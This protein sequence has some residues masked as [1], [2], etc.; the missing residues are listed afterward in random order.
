MSFEEFQNQARLYVIGALDLEELE[1]L[2]T[3]RKKSGE[4]ADDFITRC[5]ALHEAFAPKCEISPP[6]L[7][8]EHCVPCFFPSFNFMRVTTDR[9][10]RSDND[11]ILFFGQ[12]L[13]PDSIFHIREEL[14]SQMNDAMKW[15]NHLIQAVSELDREIS[16]KAVQKR[17]SSDAIFSSGV[18]NLLNLRPSQPARQKWVSPLM[19]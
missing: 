7:E 6:W 15:R 16:R 17:T 4:K 12:R 8:K 3:E 9:Y 11:Q 5:Y 1:E 14:V 2:E 10:V 19:D 18:R 13:H